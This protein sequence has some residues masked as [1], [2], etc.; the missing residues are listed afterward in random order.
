MKFKSF[1]ELFQYKDFLIFKKSLSLMCNRLSV[2]YTELMP[3]IQTN[4]IKRLPYDEDLLKQLFN[5]RSK[6]N[7]DLYKKFLTEIAPNLPKKLK[8]IVK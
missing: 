5:I 3:L 6:D 4:E 8:K 7:P 2:L 1:E